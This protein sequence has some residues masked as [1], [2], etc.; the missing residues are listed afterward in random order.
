MRTPT[1]IDAPT[2][3]DGRTIL[4]P[5]DIL[6]ALLDPVFLLT[7]F[8]DRSGI[9][10]D[11]TI[12][13]ANTTAADYYHVRREDMIRSRLL[14]FLPEDNANV[15]LALARDAYDSGEPLVVNDFAFALEIY[16]RERRFDI[17]AVRLDDHLMWTWRDVTERHLAA[18]RLASSE[19]RYRLLA[20]NSSD[21]VARIRHGSILWISPSV[22]PTFGW[23]VDECV[24]K[25]LED[26]VEPSDR[27]RCAESVARIEA[28]E[29]VLGRH[30]ILAKDGTH[31]WIET[32]ASPFLNGYGRPDG[33]V[34][35]SR[36]VDDQVAVEQ[37]LEHRARTDELTQL[38]NRK[39]VLSRIQTLNGQSRR[40]G[41]ELAVL[42]CDIDRFKE[43][44]DSH[45]HAAGD[46]VLRAMAERLRQTLRTSDDLAARIGGDELLV[47]LHGVQDLSNAVEIAEKLRAA[48]AEPVAIAGGH[49]HATLS[50]GATL[51]HKG[52]STDALVARADTAM[53]R[54]KQGGR[55]RVVTFDGTEPHAA[56]SV[57]P[58]GIVT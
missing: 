34:A 16:G 11:F 2:S 27:P 26:F 51:A 32:H 14:R 46:E 52:E 44:N 33:F 45:G 48:A 23:S 49:V 42:F 10:T 21:V 57:V 24:G 56:Q 4:G 31:H 8:R 58:H 37:Q 6:D 29:T 18:K 50:I 1:T 53:Y 55:N 9:I 30:R 36:V 13:D 17:R 7:P 41:H 54:A 19:E 38:L 40:T 25:K 20:E 43:I 5:H 28:G 3:G 22:L 47:V 35:T 15:L 39:E 12:T